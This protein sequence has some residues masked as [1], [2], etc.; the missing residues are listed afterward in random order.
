MIGK[1]RVSGILG[2]GGMGNVYAAKDPLIKRDVA[3]KILPPE[4]VGDPATLE[5]FLAEAQA[6][7]K[8]NHPHV[9][10]I[11]E[12]VQ[13][14]GGGYAIVMELVGGGS[15]QNY[16]AKKGPPG[17]RGATRIIGEA[18]KALVAAHDAGLIH[19]DIKPANL[20][21][22]NDGHVKIADFGLVKNDAA[23]AQISTQAGAI[24]GTPAF[25]SPEQCRGEKIDARTDIYSLGCT[26]YAMLT[27]KPPFEAESSMQVMFAHCSAPIPDPRSLAADV[28]EDCVRILTRALAKDPNDRYATARDLL[29]DLRGVLGGATISGPSPLAEMSRNDGAPA[30]GSR[31]RGLL[32]AQRQRKIDRWMIVALAA[33]VVVL[34]VMGAVLSR[35]IWGP[36]RT[37]VTVTA[38]VN[39]TNAAAPIPTAPIASGVSEIH[40]APHEGGPPPRP[41]NNDEP[42]MR[43]SHPPF[44][45]HPHGPGNSDRHE[46]PNGRDFPPPPPPRHEVPQVI[47]EPQTRPAQPD[48]PPAAT[49]L[50]VALPATQPAVEARIAPPAS[51][52]PATEPVPSAAPAPAQDAPLEAAIT[53]SINMKLTLI[54]PGKFMMGDNA[55]TDAPRHEATI[56]KPFYM[57]IYEVTQGEFR[58]VMGERVALK[59]NHDELPANFIGWNEAVEFCRLLNERAE[60]QQ[61]GRV[62]RLPTEAE[63]EYA[64]RAGTTTRF[65]F[66]DTLKSTQASFGKKMPAPGKFTGPRGGNGLPPGGQGGPPGAQGGPP[67]AQGGPPGAQGGPP[68][69]QGG[70]PGAQGGPPGAQGGPPGAQGGPPNEPG[71]PPRPQ[72]GPPDGPGRPPGPQ[73]GPRPGQGGPPDRPG[74]Q[75]GPPLAPTGQ[76]QPPLEPGGRF[77]PNAWGL[78]DM[79]GSTWEWCSDFYSQKFDLKQP[80]IDPT[81]PPKGTTHVSRGGSWATFANQCASA[82]RNGKPVDGSKDPTYGFRVVCEVH[83]KSPR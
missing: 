18:C 36:G 3:I 24:L 77:A 74:A 50:A 55:L 68:G 64:C 10:T 76:A 69:A 28:P 9:V 39:G 15:V 47:A 49:Q 65:A 44:G 42:E 6:A 63:W 58:A 40:R 27:N 14:G 13:V 34:L 2:H 4:L 51:A 59:A 31:G 19:R 45:E 80:Q 75:G 46:R 25:M 53:N 56:S 29:A 43:P 20:L 7:G 73:G 41:R 71:R 67:G 12:V 8:L 81:G 23:G 11:Y 62:Y 1:Y 83:G 60:E 37:P 52:P 30:G 5:R 70:P 61:A 82:Y 32:D 21:L 22:T 79:H 38:P 54:H 26:Y 16:L 72:N 78:F 66:G 33:G 57:G 48:G 17:W 35:M